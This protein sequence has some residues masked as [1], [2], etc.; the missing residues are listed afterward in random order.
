MQGHSIEGEHPM[1]ARC[2]SVSSSSRRRL[3]A[4]LRTI[5][6]IAAFSAIVAGCGA[7]PP[8]KE[9]RDARETYARAKRGPA[10]ELAPAELD[11]AKKA[12]GRAELAYDDG[13][14]DKEV[15][16]LGYIADRKSLL[17]EAAAEMRQAEAEKLAA[18]AKFKEVSEQELARARDQI[19]AEKDRLE[20]ERKAREAA[21]AARLAAE[22]GR[23]AAEQARLA[24]EKARADAERQLQSALASLKDMAAIREEQRGMVITLNGAVVFVTGKSELLPIAREKLS[25]VAKALKDQGQPPLR[26]EGHTDS[27]GSA[28]DNRKLSQERAEAVKNHLVSEGYAAAKITTIGHG[29]DRPV[30]DNTTPEGRANNRRVEIIVN[31]KS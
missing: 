3:G 10:A 21:E 16:D 28:A 29:P 17:A 12:L 22:K 18:E 23:D 9:L 11:T 24:A 4:A 8:P 26:V 5:P 13:P 14:S 20:A 15:R 30:A 2:S 7:A 25:Q 6:A 19:K 31:P 1:N 27:T